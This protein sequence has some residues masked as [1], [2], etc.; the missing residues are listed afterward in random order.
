MSSN[1][2]KALTVVLKPLQDLEYVFAQLLTARYVGTAT[3]IYLDDVGAL[4]GQPR[5]GVTDDD[6]YRRHVRAR[7]SAN[8]SK[9]LTEDVI[10]VARAVLGDVAYRVVVDNTGIAALVVRIADKALPSA[11]ATILIDMERD[12]VAAGVRI[13][14]EWSIVAPT[15]TFVIA[16]ATYLDGAHLAGVTT[17]NVAAGGPTAWP[18]TGSVLIDAGTAAEETVAYTS[19]TS[20]AITCAATANAHDTLA[21]VVLVDGAGLGFATAQS[22][23]TAALA[24]GEASVVVASTTGFTATGTITI[25]AGLAVEETLAYDALTPTV[26]GLA[27]TVL[28]ANA[29]TYA[30]SPTGCSVTQGG[31]AL[32]GV[33]E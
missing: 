13:L 22:T 27:P 12:T 32:S 19:H 9:G 2:K 17:L 21:E 25:D 28:V 11:V 16:T 8:R 18:L 30:P 10:T 29:H 6:L 1:V 5:N 15:D 20:S 31:G 7:I 33:A 14:I 24:G 23:L 3:G 4:V 26:I